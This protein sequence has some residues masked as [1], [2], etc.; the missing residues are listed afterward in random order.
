MDRKQNKGKWQDV[1]FLDQQF[2]SQNNLLK[3][4]MGYDNQNSP[5]L[6]QALIFAN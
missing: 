5:E 6:E 4:L 2:Y 3:Y 1:L